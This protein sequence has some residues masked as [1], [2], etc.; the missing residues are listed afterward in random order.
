MKDDT[1]TTLLNFVLYT[2]VILCVFFAIWSMWRVRDLKQLEPRVQ[3]HAQMVQVKRATAM[4]LLNDVITYNATAKSP[5]LAQIVQDAKTP[6][7]AAK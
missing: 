3:A 5:E 6:Q 2:L 1:T 7:P 4:A